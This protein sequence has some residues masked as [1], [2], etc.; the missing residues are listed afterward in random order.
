MDHL[1]FRQLECRSVDDAD[2]ALSLLLR[3][4]PLIGIKDDA[5]CQV[6]PYIVP[7]ADIFFSWHVGK[8]RAFE[9]S[10]QIKNF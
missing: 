8:Q 2:L 4:L 9:V 1:N 6:H 3:Q 10:M 5:Y 7:Y